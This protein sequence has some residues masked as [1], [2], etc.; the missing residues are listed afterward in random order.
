MCD[1]VNILRFLLKIFLLLWL[2]CLNTTLTFL[3][4]LF[5]S[6]LRTPYDPLRSL[7]HKLPVNLFLLSVLRL[8]TSALCR[9]LPDLFP[10]LALFPSSSHISNFLITISTDFLSHQYLKFNIL[11]S[12]HTIYPIS[13][14]RSLL[15][16]PVSA[17]EMITATPMSQAKNLEVITDIYSSS[18]LTHTPTTSEILHSSPPSQM[19]CHHP[20]SHYYEILSPHWSLKW[21][22]CLDLS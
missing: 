5:A 6:L 8:P 21:S 12:D 10:V 17:Y 1:I 11:R 22:L 7:Y 13:N 2:L 19:L 3:L 9:G 20:R 4:H 16:A 14:T 15:W 18:S